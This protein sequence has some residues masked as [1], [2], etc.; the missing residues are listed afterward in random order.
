MKRFQNADARSHVK[1]ERKQSHDRLE[2][3]QRVERGVPAHGPGLAEMREA[4]VGLRKKS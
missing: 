1:A 3:E 4:R 2:S